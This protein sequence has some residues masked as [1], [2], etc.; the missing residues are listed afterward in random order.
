MS[1]CSFRGW[2]TLHS[3]QSGVRRVNRSMTPSFLTAETNLV[4]VRQLSPS[5]L[6]STVPYTSV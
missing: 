6:V 4:P 5:L 1:L 3:A 2:L